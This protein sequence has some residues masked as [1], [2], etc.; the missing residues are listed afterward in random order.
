MKF[1]D[2][3]DT[4]LLDV[5]VDDNSYRYRAIMGDNDLTLYYSL[6][7]HVELP[8]GAW[9]EYQG[10]VYTLIRPEALKM[11]HSRLFEYTVTLKAAQAKAEMWKFRCIYTGEKAALTDGRLK[12]PFT[13][14]PREHLQMFVNNMNYR[15]SGWTIGECI[16][17]VNKEISYNHNYCLEALSI[18]ADEFE[19]EYEIVGKTVSLHKVEYNKSTPLALKYGKGNGLKPD[20]GRSNSGENPPVE[21]LYVQGGTEN[22]DASKY[23]SSE[24]HLPKGGAI[25]YDGEHFENEVGFVLAN[26][27]QY[28]C[29]T[30]GY[31]IRRADKELSSKAEDSLDCSDYYPKRVGTVG[32]VKTLNA[33]KNKYAFIDET[34][35]DNLDYSK[36]VIAGENMT[37]IFQDGM[38][39][40][41]EFEVNYS[42]GNWQDRQFTIIPQEF[43]GVTMPNE[44]FK[45]KEGDPYAVFHCALPD[46]YINDAATKS[47]AEWDIFREGVRYM[48]DNEE[49]K[50]TFSGTLDGIWSKKDWENI[51]GKVCLGGYIKFSDTRFQQDSVLVRITA[52]K[53]Y[54]NKP[55]SPEVELSNETVSSGF[56]TSFKQVQNQEVVVEESARQQELFTKRRFKDSLETMELLEASLLDNFTNSV[57][58]VAVQTMQTIIG[59]ESLQFRFVTDRTN[60]ILDSDFKIEF[61]KDTKQLSITAS[62]LQHLTLGIRSLSGSHD[63]SEYKFWDIEEYLSAVLDD[64]DKKYYLYAK[65]S[66]TDDTDGKFILSADAVQMESVGGYYH[67][68][69]GV[70]NSEYDG[71]RSFATLYG[72]TEILPSRVLT[73]KVVSAD[74]KSYLDLLSGEMR[75]GD[76]LKYMAGVLTLDFLFS[77]GADIGGW[78]FRNNRLESQNGK[79][80]LDGINN[81][82]Q[83]EG[84]FAGTLTANNLVLPFT[85]VNN[86]YT[87]QHGDKTNILL[88]GAQ[89]QTT[90]LTLPSDDVSFDGMMLNVYWHPYMTQSDGY[91]CIIG[92]IFCPTKSFAGLSTNSTETYSHPFYASK[93]EAVSGGFVQ[94]YNRMGAWTLV[95]ASANLT[96]TVSGSTSI[97]GALPGFHE[98][99]AAGTYYL[100]S[101]CK[102]TIYCRA[103]SGAVTFYL[104]KKSRVGDRIEIVKLSGASLTLKIVDTETT[105]FN[106]NGTL[107]DSVSISASAAGRIIIDRLSNQMFWYVWF[108]KRDTSL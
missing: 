27:R 96:Y 83:A 66:K 52:I 85:V 63:V 61:N 49:Q 68:L 95:N 19:T 51:G 88:V 28:V 50:F 106:N 9:C 23:G 77:E 43:D 38:L 98:V 46:E 30:D 25:S 87:L 102:P 84:G 78:V 79:V 91:A 97:E 59:D 41:K 37:I 105:K 54:I 42:H 1:Y 10:E 86:D 62:I 57:N 24:L 99:S 70:L 39:A 31:S 60:P 40:G 82:I 34:I 69:V 90:T 80:W 67:F 6:A 11:K 74:G 65:C 14:T 75:L 3:E 93:I 55:H 4:L 35:P 56:A 20:V 18:I 21:I 89:G 36:Y 22:I 58:P 73:D 101:E 107:A 15:D 17:G 45:P 81:E 71:E 47:G 100:S 48:F 104:P 13:A 103:T 12:F 76:K 108:V 2:S 53:D 94:L 5:D 72:Y 92:S 64:A 26:S 32:I 16:D 29:D 7:E 44:T 33:A 8:V